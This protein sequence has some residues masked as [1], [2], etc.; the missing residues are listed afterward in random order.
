M[1]AKRKQM[2]VTDRIVIEMGLYA[3][4]SFKQIAKTLDRHPKTI[5]REVLN[6]A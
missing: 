2:D 1:E 5:Q 4:R 6:T 3:N